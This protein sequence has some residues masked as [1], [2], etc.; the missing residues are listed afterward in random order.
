MKNQEWFLDYVATVCSYYAMQLGVY[1]SS[2][3]RCSADFYAPRS[4]ERPLGPL[5]DL[6]YAGCWIWTSENTPST[7]LV[8]KGKKKGQGTC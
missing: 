5:A 4:R 3:T 6:G 1:L 2:T 8:N 7:R